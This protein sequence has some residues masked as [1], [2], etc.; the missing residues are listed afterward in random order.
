MGLPEVSTI[1]WR[2]RQLLELLVFKLDAQQ[3][4][5]GSGRDR[6]L[7]HAS[8]ELQLVMEELQH[9]E[10]LRAMEVDSVASSLGLPPGVSLA[11]L[12]DAAPAP[13]DDLFRQ[14]RICLLELS[15]EVKDRS[16]QNC[17][18]LARGQSALRE[19]IAVAGSTS[20]AGAVLPD[21]PA[22]GILVDRV[23]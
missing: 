19:L 17:E 16:R 4:L 1:L 6:W 7:T 8:D 2:E 11:E 10:L 5:I 15:S 3:L 14:H 23:F 22:S 13:F 12:A 20:H 18:A 21:E 9:V